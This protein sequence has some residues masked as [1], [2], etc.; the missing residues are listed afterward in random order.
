MKRGYKMNKILIMLAFFSTSVFSN[1]QFIG[2]IL[3]SS[4]GRWGAIDEYVQ[5]KADQQALKKCKLKYNKCNIMEQYFE[6][7]H[8]SGGGWAKSAVTIVEGE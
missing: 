4:N 5:E 7:D 1:E 3:E 2:H 8:I 6:S